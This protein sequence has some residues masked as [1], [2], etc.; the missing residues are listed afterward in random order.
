MVLLTSQSSMSVMAKVLRVVVEHPNGIRAREISDIL[1]QE[2]QGRYVDEAYVYHAINK[3]WI[4]KGMVVSK[5]DFREG[6]RRACNYYYP[7][8][9]GKEE[10]R[11]Y[12]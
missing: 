9:L 1:S 3:T 2:E 12:D 10:I 4:P 5:K 6:C 8:E 7:T 11:K